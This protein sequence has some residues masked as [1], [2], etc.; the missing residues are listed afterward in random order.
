MGTSKNR[1]E[2]HI[3][4]RKRRNCPVLLETDAV[5]KR[6]KYVHLG[7]KN[8]QTRQIGESAFLYDL[9]KEY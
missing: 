5:L 9:V 6:D 1:C 2:L 3:F 8:V 4:S 7:M